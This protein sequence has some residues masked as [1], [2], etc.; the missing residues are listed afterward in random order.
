[1]IFPLAVILNRLAAA[2]LVLMPFGRRINCSVVF[3]KEHA[4]YG[5]GP[6]ESSPILGCL[7]FGHLPCRNPPGPLAG[8]LGG[9]PDQCLTLSGPVRL[10]VCG[11]NP[12]NSGN[13]G[14]AQ[15]QRGG[16]A[17]KWRR[18]GAFPRQGWWHPRSE[19]HTSELQP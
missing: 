16:P 10:P 17:R 2:F 9:N 14:V 3:Q 4:I 1:M 18:I 15:E 19:E 13:V 7:A 11:L 12:A 5:A 6:T 8:L